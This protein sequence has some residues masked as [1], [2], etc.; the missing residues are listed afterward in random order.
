MDSGFRRNDEIDGRMENKKIIF[1]NRYF[2]PDHS[3]TSQL[4][5]DLAFHLAAQDQMIYVITSRQRYDDP[6][7]ELES[8]KITRGVN[9]YRVWTSSFGRAKLI[10][11]VAD[12][13]SFYISASWMLFKLAHKG[14]IVIAK[15]DPPL[16]SICAAYICRIRRAQLYN[17]LQDLFPEVAAALEVKGISVGLYKYLRKKRN[18]SLR[19]ARKNIVLGNSMKKIL[20]ANHI[21]PSKIKVIPNW[22]DEQAIK[23]VKPEDN[24]LRHSWGLDKKFVVGYSG[25]M[26]RAHDLNIIMEAAEKL[27]ENKKIHFL[28]IGGGAQLQMLQKVAINWKLDNVMFQPYQERDQLSASLSVADLHLISLKQSLEGLIVP[29]KFYGIAAVGRPTIYLG[30]EIGELAGVIKEASCGYAIAGDDVMEFCELLTRLADDPELCQGMGIQAR[31]LFEQ[32]YTKTH[33]LMEWEQL[34][35]G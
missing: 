14:D 11:R 23:P 6:N 5:T 29:S 18:Q 12:Y 32:R 9:I 13:L 20:W 17:W 27:M 31:Q 1:L 30:D 35:I 34:L 33:A 28:F 26:G 7:A 24:F 3:A 2:Y 15:T 21:S 25:N 8:R 19:F 4:L 16:I 10:G 22:A